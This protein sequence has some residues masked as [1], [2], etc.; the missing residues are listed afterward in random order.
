MP[1]N[2]MFIQ[3]LEGVLEEF[4]TRNENGKLPKKFSMNLIMESIREI[5]NP[6]KEEKREKKGKGKITPYNHFVRENMSK[7]KDDFPKISGAERMVELGK[8][9]QKHKIDNPD[10][11]KDVVKQDDKKPVKK[12]VKKVEVKKEEVK[13]AEV[14][15]DTKKK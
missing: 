6:L 15:K 14:K 9:W 5:S 3:V 1:K 13:K 10:Y 8:R 4:K 12:V 11:N 7:V 2:S